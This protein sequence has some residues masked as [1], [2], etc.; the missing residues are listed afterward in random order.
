[1]A[2]K[3]LHLLYM[4]QQVTD[5]ISMCYNPSGLSPLANHPVHLQIPKDKELLPSAFI[6]FCSF[7]TEAF[8]LGTKVCQ[9]NYMPK[10]SK[11]SP[12]LSSSCFDSNKM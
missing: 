11:R 2:P 1:M 5:M 10:K 3:F 4:I 12:L 6:P 9:L 8:F 7:G